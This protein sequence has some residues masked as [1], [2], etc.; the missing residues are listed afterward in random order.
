M[1]EEKDVKL[2]VISNYAN[3]VSS[4]GDTSILPFKTAYKLGLLGNYCEA[5]LEVLQKEQTKRVQKYNRERESLLT[6][7][8]E[9][10]EEEIPKSVK[11]ELVTLSNTLNEE[12]EEIKEMTAK[13]K[14][15]SFTLGEFTA[16]EDVK[17]TIVVKNKE[18]NKVETII[19][20]KG[21]ALVPVRFFKLMGD[22]IEDK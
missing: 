11:N 20:K 19:I 14:L 22:L 21:Q 17:Q 12:L 18:E 5:P 8:K 6:C 9:S 15:P 16:S 7:Y 10:K 2:S 3:A 13:I 4:I 1:G